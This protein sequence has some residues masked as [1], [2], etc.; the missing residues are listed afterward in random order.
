MRCIWPT[1]ALIF[2]SSVAWSEPFGLRITVQSSGL[3]SGE[4]NARLHYALERTSP[5]LVPV[6]DSQTIKHDGRN[7]YSQFVFRFD[8]LNFAE[9]AERGFLWGEIT[10]SRDRIVRRIPLVTFKETDLNDRR[11]LQRSIGTRALGIPALSGSYPI[12]LADSGFLDTDNVLF[13]LQAVRVLI[14][15]GFVNSTA[16]WQRIFDKFTANV[17]FFKR[18]GAEDVGRIVRYLHERYQI[19][20]GSDATLDIYS[21]FYFRFLTGLMELEIG[22][23]DAPDGSRLDTYTINRMRLLIGDQGVDLL[24]ETLDTQAALIRKRNASAC[25]EVSHSMLVEMNGNEDFWAGI[26][27]VE[28]RERAIKVF[29][30]RFVDCSQRYYQQT[31]DDSASMNLFKEGFANLLLKENSGEKLASD[32]FAV[33]QKLESAGRFPQTQRNGDYQQVYLYYNEAIERLGF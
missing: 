14:D 23:L 27:S 32:F 4:L 18:G 9:D 6:S 20:S 17:D 22:G 11:L 15:S 16:E 30:K 29:L 13:S 8:G 31:G 25:L 12:H 33:V 1:I 5:E 21:R 28:G 26:G 10:D 19:L 2:W 3:P 24:G 7:R